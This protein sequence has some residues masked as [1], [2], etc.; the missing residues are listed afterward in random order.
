MA[1]WLDTPL[2]RA[3]RAMRAENDAARQDPANLCPKC[4]KPKE[5]PFAPVRGAHVVQ[6]GGST[7][8]RGGGPA[9][10]SEMGLCE[11]E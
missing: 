8:D 1:G 6:R 2:M 4:G 9:S 11:C 5:I 3:K 10:R 7:Y